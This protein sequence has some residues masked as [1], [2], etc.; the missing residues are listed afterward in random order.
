MPQPYPI[1]PTNKNLVEA[2]TISHHNRNTYPDVN[3]DPTNAKFSMQFV[4]TQGYTPHLGQDNQS[5]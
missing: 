4:Q 3:I 1:Y 5:S 2:P